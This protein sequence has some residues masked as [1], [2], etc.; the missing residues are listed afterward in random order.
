MSLELLLAH[1]I[2]D[3]IPCWLDHLKE[4]KPTGTLP[5]DKAKAKLVKRITLTYV[6]I[7]GALYKRS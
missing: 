4:Y 6:V 5:T 2:Q 3:Q 1:P 7:G